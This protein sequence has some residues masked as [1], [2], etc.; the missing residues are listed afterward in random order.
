MIICLLRVVVEEK[1]NDMET[2]TDTESSSSPDDCA[3]H[4][5]AW[6]PVYPK[7]FGA[8]RGKILFHHVSIQMCCISADNRHLVKASSISAFGEKN[9]KAADE[10]ANTSSTEAA[11]ATRKKTTFR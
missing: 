9:Q 3:K 6:E 11:A 4:R 7:R 10:A 1:L 5:N 8:H 2:V